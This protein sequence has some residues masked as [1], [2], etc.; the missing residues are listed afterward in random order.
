MRSEPSWPNHLLKAPPP[1]TVTLW[2]KVLFIFFSFETVTLSFR[3]ECNGMITAH[4]SLNLP[5]SSYSCASAS[6]I[7]GTTDTRHHAGLI[8]CIFSRDGVSFTM[9]ARVVSNSGPR[10]PP[11]LASQSAGITGVGY[12]SQSCFFFIYFYLFIYFETE[13]HSVT[14]AGVQW[15]NLSSLQP[16]PPRFKWLSCLSLPSSWDYRRPPPHPATS[17]CIFSR[18]GVSPRWSDWS[19]TPDLR[20]SAHLG[21]PKC[22]DY[23][24]EPSCLAKRTYYIL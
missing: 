21:L 15:P 18:D 16:P 9:L 22:W 19:Q 1:N 12:R 7:V 24:C 3:L 2:I 10:D 6:W 11:T 17:F 20:W 4:C 5:G 8:F 14:Q 23:R 13:S